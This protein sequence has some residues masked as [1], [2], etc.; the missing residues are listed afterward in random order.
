M[1]YNCQFS[2]IGQFLFSNTIKGSLQNKTK[3]LIDAI[4]SYYICLEMENDLCNLTHTHTPNLEMLSHLKT[5]NLM[6]QNQ[7]NGVEQLTYVTIGFER[8]NALI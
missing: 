5:L 7:R 3:S 8:H 2:I 6:Q 1:I 4:T